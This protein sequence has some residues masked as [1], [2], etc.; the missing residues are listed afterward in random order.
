MIS[1]REWYLWSLEEY[2][3]FVSILVHALY[4]YTFSFYVSCMYNNIDFNMITLMLYLSYFIKYTLLT[5]Q[6]NSH[7]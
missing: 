1:E 4:T 7:D 6:N 5:V 3:A 2:T